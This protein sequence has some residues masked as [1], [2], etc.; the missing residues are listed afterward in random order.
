VYIKSEREKRTKGKGAG[1]KREIQRC[2][3]GTID[4]SKI[5][6]T[7]NGSNDNENEDD[8]SGDD[9]DD[10]DDDN[11]NDREDDVNVVRE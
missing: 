5:V 7:Q 4:K 8:G 6:I 1:V 2:P 9:G 3:P 10:D 11:D